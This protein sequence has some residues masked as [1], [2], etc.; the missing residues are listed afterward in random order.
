[1]LRLWIQFRSVYDTFGSVCARSFGDSEKSKRRGDC[2]ER[3]V[4]A[5]DGANNDAD[6]GAERAGHD[7]F[8]ST[9]P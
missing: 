2:D 6:V 3:A 7:S 8:I 5:I 1:M 9:S 4:S